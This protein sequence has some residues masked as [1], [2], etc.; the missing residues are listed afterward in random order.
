MKKY[1][2]VVLLLSLIFTG[3]ADRGSVEEPAKI[4][5]ENKSSSKFVFHDEY[6]DT[7]CT[8]ESYE[9]NNYGY[10]ILGRQHDANYG[11]IKVDNEYYYFEELFR[12]IENEEVDSETGEV[13]LIMGEGRV[14]S[15]YKLEGSNMSLNIDFDLSDGVSSSGVV[16][17]V[18]KLK[19]AYLD[20]DILEM[21]YEDAVK[22]MTDEFVNYMEG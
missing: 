1:L 4:V 13:R 15:V 20:G 5:S 14:C 6:G 7:A 16:K 11:M 9:D 12:V 8:V 10:V 3:C 19:S 22:K 18:D 2:V 17:S 21:S